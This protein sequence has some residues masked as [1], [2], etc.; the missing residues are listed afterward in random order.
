MICNTLYI[1]I[2]SSCCI[3]ALKEFDNISKSKADGNKKSGYFQKVVSLIPHKELGVDTGTRFLQ[4]VGLAVVSG[5]LGAVT[6]LTSVCRGGYVCSANKE[7]VKSSP[8]LSWNCKWNFCSLIFFVQK[9]EKWKLR[10]FSLL[11]APSAIQMNGFWLQ[12]F[13][14]VLYLQS[15]IQNDLKLTEQ[16][17]T[18]NPS[19]I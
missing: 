9:N 6:L 17:L 11:L 1:Q 8:L 4:Y 12:K 2:T 14:S 13:C 10:T 5:R 18:L 19:Y 7:A 16:E 3:P 15:E